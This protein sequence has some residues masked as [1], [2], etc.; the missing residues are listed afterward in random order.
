MA[1][2]KTDKFHWV[3]DSSYGGQI[4]IA[5]AD[6]R[7]NIL[8]APSLINLSKEER[9]SIE[10]LNLFTLFDF[11]DDFSVILCTPE[12]SKNLVT[13]TAPLYTKGEISGCTV[14]YKKG[15]YSDVWTDPKDI[16]SICEFVA[17]NIPSEKI[18]DYGCYVD[19]KDI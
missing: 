7:N 15:T 4:S 17:N 16:Q 11:S 3:V 2:I 8:C 9:R 14:Y 10:D 18:K 5:L 6:S 19:M 13:V 1:E 12:E